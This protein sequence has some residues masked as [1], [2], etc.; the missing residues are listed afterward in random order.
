MSKNIQQVFTANPIVTNQSTDLMYFGR[1]PYGNTD[2]CAMT[3]ANFAAQFGGGGGGGLIKVTSVVP[4][5]GIVNFTPQAGTQNI[6]VELVGG[7]SGGGN[8][9]GGVGTS[10]IGC[11]GSGGGYI[12]AYFPNFAAG[13]LARAGAAGAGAAAGSTTGGESGVASFFGD[14]GGTLS[15]QGI[16]GNSPGSNT[17]TTS[18]NDIFVQTLGVPGGEANIVAMPAGCIIL[19][20]QQGQA[21]GQSVTLPVGFGIPSWIGGSALGLGWQPQWAS[22]TPG[23]NGLGNGC[24][25]G[26]GMSLANDQAGG[27]GSDGIINIYEYS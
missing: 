3:Y 11:A 14:A 4:A 27:N 22:D 13:Y 16:G 1:S 20:A 9:T 5:D 15:L 23:A 21:S 7:G 2:D 18:V 24:G 26:G 19:S 10:S 6:L 8:S 17:V 25:G 12:K